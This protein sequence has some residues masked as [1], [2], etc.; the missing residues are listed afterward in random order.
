M[1]HWSKVTGPAAVAAVYLGLS[2]AI[3]WG[4][5]P[6]KAI[7]GALIVPLPPYATEAAAYSFGWWLGS[8]I[9]H[10]D[11]PPSNVDVFTGLLESLTDECDPFHPDYYRRC[12][13]VSPFTGI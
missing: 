2:A 5:P 12:I 8:G 11:D 10:G 1:T 9:G 6:L 4:P 13:G 7:A 3:L